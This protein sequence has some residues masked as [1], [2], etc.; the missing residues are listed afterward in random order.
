MRI[1][2]CMGY[3][4][5]VS[6]RRYRQLL[7]T[8]AK[9]DEINWDSVGEPLADGYD[10]LTDVDAEEAKQMLDDLREARSRAKGGAK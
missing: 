5:R 3:V 2:T 4:Y 6:E 9:G 10:N 7:Q 8:L 1:V